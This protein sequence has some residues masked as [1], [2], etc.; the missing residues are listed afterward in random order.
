MGC[1][2]LMVGGGGRS[3]LQLAKEGFRRTRK[4]QGISHIFGPGEK[5]EKKN[6]VWKRRIS[7]RIQEI[8]GLF[9]YQGSTIKITNFRK[10]Y[11]KS[12]CFHVG[13]PLCLQGMVQIKC[14][15]TRH[16]PSFSSSFPDKR[17]SLVFTPSD[18]GGLR[19]EN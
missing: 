5:K 8:Q 10:T 9:F 7:Q 4:E 19:G 6:L 12:L 15:L 17:V 16:R 13:N 18:G 3:K 11:T 14:V 2:T 1:R